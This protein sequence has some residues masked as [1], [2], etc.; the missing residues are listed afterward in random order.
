MREINILQVLFT[1]Q[2]NDDLQISFQ[3]PDG[4]IF[5]DRVTMYMVGIEDRDYKEDKVECKF[6]FI[7][8]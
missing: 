5:P 2:S 3:K 6:I 7:Q 1:Q 4:V 8:N